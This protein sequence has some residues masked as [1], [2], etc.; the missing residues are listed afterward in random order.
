VRTLGLIAAAVAAAAAFVILSRGG[1]G[2]VSTNNAREAVVESR[3]ANVEK[4]DGRGRVELA[5]DTRAASA[6]D[7]AVSLGPDRGAIDFKVACEARGG[8][9]RTRVVIT[10]YRFDRRPAP[11]GIVAVQSGPRH[12]YRGGAEAGSPCRLR[13]GNVLCLSGDRRALKAEGRFWV[14]GAERCALGVAVYEVEPASCVRRG[15]RLPLVV[16]Y[17]RRGSPAGCP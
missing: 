9:S 11:S 1:D 8:N 13:G 2:G 4:P 3:Q 12:P 5:S 16:T 6:C 17:L 15:C 7:A 10:R 14:E